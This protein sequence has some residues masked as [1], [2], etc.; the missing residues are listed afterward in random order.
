MDKTII[1]VLVCALG[2]LLLYLIFRAV[3][4]VVPEYRRLSVYRGGFYLGERGPGV[5]ILN[6]L[7][8]RT[9]NIDLREQTRLL[10]P[11]T[12]MTSEGKAVRLTAVWFFKVDNTYAFLNQVYDFEKSMR[13]LVQSS[14]VGMIAATPHDALLP[15]LE[16]LNDRLLQKIRQDGERWGVEIFRLEIE[17]IAFL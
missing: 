4:R 11:Q 5:L 1:I 3:V 13:R 15:S 6:P 14:L 10:A 7:I 8:D 2:V 16:A 9:K 17:Q 12:Y